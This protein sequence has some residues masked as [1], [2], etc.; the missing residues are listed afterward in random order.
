LADI[1][2][3]LHRRGRLLVAEPLF[4]PREAHGRQPQRIVVDPRTR[5]GGDKV[6]AGDLV[7]VA[8]PSRVK[9]KRATPA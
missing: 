8:R 9:S 2:A 4:P 7:L 3:V 1:V 5:R 6:N